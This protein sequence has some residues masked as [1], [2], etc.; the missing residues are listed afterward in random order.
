V[1]A[2]F[3]PRQRHFFFAQRRAVRL[4]FTGFVRR[5]ETDSGATD[6]Q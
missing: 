3:L 4:L 6:N 2:Q 1:P 5:A